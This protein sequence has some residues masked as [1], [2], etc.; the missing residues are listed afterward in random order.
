M[1]G[2]RLGNQGEKG[3]NT[4]SID[5]TSIIESAKSAKDAFGDVDPKE[6]RAIGVESSSVLLGAAPLLQDAKVQYYV[7]RVGY[8][9]AQQTERPDLEWRFAVL[10][11]DDI[12]SFAAPGGFVFVTKGLLLQL[13]NEAE[14]APVL[15]HECAHVV[16]R[17]YL[18]AVKKNARL[19]LSANLVSAAVKTDHKDTLNKVLAGSRE[20]YARGL[21]KDDEYET[22]RM[23]AVLSARAGYEPFG[24][25]HVMQRL[26]TVN[27][28]DGSLSFMFK[29]HPSPGQ[30]LDELEVTVDPLADYAEGPF[31]RE[32]YQAE[33]SAIHRHWMDR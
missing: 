19:D 27:P 26:A 5:L 1:F 24:L 7:N 20:L 31:L 32:R 17:H 16:Q 21:D 18:A 11:V 14:L 25:H 8:W 15:A 33:T 3:G 28:D 13:D 6:E 4:Q 12:N 30:R 2:G 10:D 29:T 22:D 23:G 9:V